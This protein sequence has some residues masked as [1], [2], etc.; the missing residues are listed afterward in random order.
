MKKSCRGL[1]GSFGWGYWGCVLADDD[2]VGEED[3]VVGECLVAHIACL[4]GAAPREVLEAYFVV[5][6]YFVVDA[7]ELFEMLA[8][9]ADA[10]DDFGGHPY[11]RTADLHEVGSDERYGLF[12][13]KVDGDIHTLATFGEEALPTKVVIV[14]S[15][16]KA[17]GESALTGG[18]VIFPPGGVVNDFFA[19]SKMLNGC[20]CLDAVADFGGKIEHIVA[21]LLHLC[22]NFFGTGPEVGVIALSLWSPSDFGE[23]DGARIEH[24]LGV[25]VGGDVFGEESAFNTLDVCSDGV[26]NIGGSRVE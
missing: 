1:V 23:S 3:A 26:R 2:F 6:D 18:G 21:A 9:V 5:A 13:A 11:I 4:G 22:G 24:I 14:P 10:Y 16:A 8:I 15:S 20:L 12:L 17:V 7:G 25:G 19:E